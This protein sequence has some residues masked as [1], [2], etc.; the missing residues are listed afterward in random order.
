MHYESRRRPG[1]GSCLVAG[2][3]LW[4]GGGMCLAGLGDTV[5]PSAEHGAIGYFN[6]LR[7]S[8]RDP[9]SELNRKL[10]QGSVRLRFD[11]DGTGYL[12]SVLEALHVSVGSQVAVFSKTSLQADRIEPRNP[13]TI[14][15]NDS[16]AVAW[17][18][19]GFIELASQDPESGVVFSVLEQQRVDHP[20]F[21]RRDDCL[22]CHLSDDSLGVPGM[23]VRSRYTAADGIPRLIY[24]GFTTDH[25]S[26]LEERWG[27]WYVTGSAGNARHLGNA[28]LA[29]EE[30]P[31]S[32]GRPLTLRLPSLAGKFDTEA[33]LSPHSDVV[34]LLLFD[35]QM[36]MM[37]LL[38]RV[39]WEIR[40]AIYDKRHDLA[41][42]LQDSARELVDYLLFVDEAP[43][44]GHIEGSS[45][46]AAEFPKQGSRDG[47]GR[48]L[49]DLDLEKRLLRYPCSYLIYAD[50]FDSL[51]A[52]AKAAIYQRMWQILSGAERGGKYAR[53][54]LADRK[55]VVE[56]LRDTKKGLP[57]YF[58]E[59]TR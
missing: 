46:F 50:A 31:E 20:E 56:I 2:V 35:H 36:H 37:N 49:R 27:G 44:S 30:S 8:W 48:S 42:R 47:R 32:M 5:A 23:V 26:P 4:M 39:G 25:R 52:E 1:L 29:G 51:P 34:A 9:V 15:F 40:A 22:R 21:R 55:A 12:R 58:R 14:F 33:Y 7:P 13:R 10:R 19:G 54:S 43:L 18:R 53:L 59:V 11:G 24:G 17:V 45:G 6:Y 3:C 41:A 28:M 16:V 57:D 38:T